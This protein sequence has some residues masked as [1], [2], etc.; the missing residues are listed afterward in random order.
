MTLSY[1]LGIP[2]FIAFNRHVVVVRAGELLPSRH[3]PKRV[4]WIAPLSISVL[5]WY[6]VNAWAFVAGFAV[7]H[8]I[9]WLQTSFV[10]RRF[11]ERTRRL[12]STAA[13]Q[14][15][16]GP[17]S[18]SADDDGLHCTSATSSAHYLWSAVQRVAV[19][20][21]HAFIYVGVAKA[22]IVPRAAVPNGQFEAFMGIVGAHVPGTFPPAATF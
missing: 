6:F 19:T 1:V 18:L 12:Y 22:F 16:L 13:G 2:D 3:L 10:P 9:W 4:H 5:L 11:D 21:T 15:E 20:D 7:W 14:A 17:Q 8:L